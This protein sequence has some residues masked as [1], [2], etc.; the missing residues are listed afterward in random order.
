MRLTMYKYSW[1]RMDPNSLHYHCLVDHNLCKPTLYYCPA[2]KITVWEFS[3][4]WKIETLLMWMSKLKTFMSTDGPSGALSGT[5]SCSSTATDERGL[6]PQRPVLRQ[7][8]VT[9]SFQHLLFLKADFIIPFIVN[10]E[11]S[12]PHKMASLM[13]KLCKPHRAVGPAKHPAVGERRCFVLCS[14]WSYAFPA[15]CFPAMTVHQALHPC[16]VPLTPECQGMGMPIF[17]D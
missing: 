13:V 9:H 10:F 11:R 8:S 17:M 15:F 2:L 3:V 14:A 4:S 16:A 5:G 7:L 1:D 12:S 6:K